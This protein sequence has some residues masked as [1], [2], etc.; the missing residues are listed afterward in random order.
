MVCVTDPWEGADSTDND[1]DVRRS[2]GDQDSLVSDVQG[3]EVLDDLEDEPGNSRQG[4]SAVYATEMLPT[5]SMSV[6][7]SAD[8]RARLT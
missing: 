5:G 2:T 8:E 7:E 4:A 1:Y 6:Q 3:F